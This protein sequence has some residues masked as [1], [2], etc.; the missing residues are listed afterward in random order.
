MVNIT[1]KYIVYSHDG[2]G[3][4]HHHFT[5]QNNIIDQINEKGSPTDIKQAVGFDKQSYN[6][7]IVPFAFMSVRGAVDGNKLYTTSGIYPVNV[8]NTDIDILVVYGPTGGGGFGPDGGPG[9]LVDAFNVDTGDFS[10]SDFIKVLT[11]PTPPDVLD[12]A[13]TDTANNDGDVSTA[14]AEN[15]RAFKEI[16][17]VLPNKMIK[18]VPFLEWKKIVPTE[19][20]LVKGKKDITIAQ[21]ESGEIWFAFYQTVDIGVIGIKGNT[22]PNISKIIRNAV[23]VWESGDDEGICPPIPHPIGPLGPQFNISIKSS[24]MNKLNPAQK[25]KLK[26]YIKKYPDI[27]NTAYKDMIKVL[28]ILNGVNNIVSKIKTK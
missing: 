22:I 11:P 13:K 18:K 15:I 3:R 16:E 1:T 4:R 28:T 24:I 5:N 9:I 12:A 2:A 20:I 23:T 27:A 10:D 21:N 19:T 26:G 6:N 17:Y 25:E 7:V 8:G 14:L